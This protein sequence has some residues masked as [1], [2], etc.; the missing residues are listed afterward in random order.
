MPCTF[1]RLCCQRRSL[2]R[3]QLP[4]QLAPAESGRRCLAC[5]DSLDDNIVPLLVVNN[6]LQTPSLD[7]TTS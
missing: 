4:V 5:R 3:C 7:L 6:V 2:V 1:E